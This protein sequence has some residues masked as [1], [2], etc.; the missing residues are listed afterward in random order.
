[1]HHF[2][3]AACKTEGHGPKGRLPSPVCNLIERCS[4]ERLAKA[5]APSAILDSA[6]ISRIVCIESGR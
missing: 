5:F 6:D 2:D 4:A 1:M 3:S